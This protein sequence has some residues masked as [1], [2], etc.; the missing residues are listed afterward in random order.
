MKRKEL[1]GWKKLWGNAGLND[2]QLRSKILIALFQ[3]PSGI[4]FGILFKSVFGTA[5]GTSLD[6][7]LQH[8]LIVLRHENLVTFEN[9][10]YTLSGTG[11]KACRT[12]IFRNYPY[13]VY[14]WKG[15]LELIITK[16]LPILLS[17]VALAF[18]ILSYNRTVK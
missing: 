12:S 3:F 15:R 8:S 14:F 7:M 1:R 6:D 16:Y 18:S 11:F 2:E 17:I 9:N 4:P 13:E 10:S 5:S